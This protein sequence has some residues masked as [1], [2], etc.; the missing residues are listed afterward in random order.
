M[1]QERLTAMDKTLKQQEN[2]LVDKDKVYQKLVEKSK[3]QRAEWQQ[4]V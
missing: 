2:L 3:N 4:V 1:L